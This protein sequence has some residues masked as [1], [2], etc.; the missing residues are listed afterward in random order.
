MKTIKI[1]YLGQG[2]KTVE[3]PVPFVSKCEKTGQ[4]ICNPV[5]EF[6][7]EDGQ[8]LLEISGEDGLFRLVEI[9]SDGNPISEPQAAK[10]ALEE[11]FCVCGCGGRIEIKPQHKKLGIPKYLP[12]H[13]FRKKQLPPSLNEGIEAPSPA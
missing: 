2:A 12:G 10:S 1:K 8:R 9:L 7:F 4:V 13:H 5:G 11:H 6:P 3:L